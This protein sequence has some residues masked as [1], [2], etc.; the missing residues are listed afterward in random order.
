MVD[1]WKSMVDSWKSMV[2]SWKSM[3][4]S[5]KSMVDSWKSMVRSL[6][7]PIGML[8][9]KHG[10]IDAKISLSKSGYVPG[11]SAVLSAEINNASSKTIARVETALLE[12]VTYTAKRGKPL[13]N[14]YGI[15]HRHSEIEKKMEVRTV[16]QYIE[17][18]KVPKNS[19]SSYMR[20]LAIPPICPS[21]NVCSIIQVD[22]Q[23]RVKIVT[24]GGLRRSIAGDLPILIGTIPVRHGVPPQQQPENLTPDRLIPPKPSMPIKFEFNPPPSHVECIFGKCTVD[25]E[26]EDKA[27][28]FTPKYIY[29]SGLK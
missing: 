2:D 14:H 29:Y 5:W 17:D 24:K 10:Y 3:V 12:V 13:L 18:F 25:E 7:K 11:E 6:S 1:S 16:V 20:M 22:Y 19:R 15:G 4:D 28:N 9:L 27:L 23:F 21:F 26:K 8:C